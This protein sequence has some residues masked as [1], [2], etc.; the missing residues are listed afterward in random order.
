MSFII[1]ETKIIETRYAWAHSQ[2]QGKGVGAG[3][4]NGHFSR[5]MYTV[6]YIDPCKCHRR[7]QRRRTGRAPPCPNVFK[8]VFLKTR[9]NFIVI[10]MQCLQYVFYSLLS[11][12]KHRVCVKGHENNLQTSKI[13]PRRDRAPRFLNSCMLTFL[14]SCC[15]RYFF[16]GSTLLKKKRCSSFDIP[17]AN[18]DEW[19]IPY[20]SHNILIWHAM[21]KELVTKSR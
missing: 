3:V 13:I 20:F 9:I 21:I 2:V 11:L 6:L 18:Y 16:S 4:I 19:F 15:I 10:N 12:Q 7:I 17:N 14:I 1:Y 5:A 8:G